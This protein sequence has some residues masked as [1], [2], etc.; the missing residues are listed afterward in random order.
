MK[1]V[2]CS[3]CRFFKYEDVQGFGYCELW[4]YDDVSSH[5]EACVEIKRKEDEYERCGCNE[6]SGDID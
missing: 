3:D 1:K 4:E 5:D 2:Y 6:G